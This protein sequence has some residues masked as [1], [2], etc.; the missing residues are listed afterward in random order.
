MFM[1]HVVWL[2]LVGAKQDIPY[3]CQTIYLIL[4]NSFVCNIPD[5]SQLVRSA[6]IQAVIHKADILD[7]KV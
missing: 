2:Q 1:A 7:L 6:L 5:L 3:Y 4:H